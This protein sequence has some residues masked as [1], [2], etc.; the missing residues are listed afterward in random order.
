MLRSDY[1]VVNP[2]PGDDTWAEW[3]KHVIHSIERFESNIDELYEKIDLMNDEVLQLRT[4]SSIVWSAIGAV[5]GTLLTLFVL[6]IL[7]MI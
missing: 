1:N 6:I 7:K 2:M 4:R 3:S 5:A